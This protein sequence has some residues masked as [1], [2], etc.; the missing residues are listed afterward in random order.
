MELTVIWL[1][2][3]S[4]KNN[5]KLKQFYAQVAANTDNA[6]EVMTVT[7][8]RTISNYEEMCSH[9][10]GLTSKWQLY[11]MRLEGDDYQ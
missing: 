6:C 10:E 11:W 8:Y 4:A 5:Y 9:R 1:S 7:I 3:E 2:L